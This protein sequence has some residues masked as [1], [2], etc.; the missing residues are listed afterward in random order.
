MYYSNIFMD[1]KTIF[2]PKTAPATLIVSGVIFLLLGYS[3]V[4]K[5]IGVGWI[6]ILLG[7]GLSLLWGFYFKNR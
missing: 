5:T 1:I 3:G 2:K 7:I 6:L 4:L